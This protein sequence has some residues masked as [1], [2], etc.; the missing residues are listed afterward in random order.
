[1]AMVNVQN[2]DSSPS[3]LTLCIREDVLGS[4]AEA[5]IWTLVTVSAPLGL[6]HPGHG[7]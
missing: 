5:R 4:R 6:E 2:R 1:M 7:R 3:P